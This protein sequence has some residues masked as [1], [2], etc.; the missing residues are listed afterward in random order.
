MLNFEFSKM[1][2][3]SEEARETRFWLR[4]IKKSNL[5]DTDLSNYLKEIDEITN[6]ITKIVK[7]SCEKMLV[8]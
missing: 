1:S 6:I 8:K 7:T 3:A 2:I 5:I 4:V